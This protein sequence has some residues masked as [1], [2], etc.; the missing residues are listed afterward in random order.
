MERVG[1]IIDR[2]SKRLVDDENLYE[3]TTWTRAVILNGLNYALQLIATVDPTLFGKRVFIPIPDTGFFSSP[4]GEIRPPFYLVDSNNSIVKE[5][6]DELP[7]STAR[8]IKI[9]TDPEQTSYVVKLSSNEFEIYPKPSKIT[10]KYRISALCVDVESVTSEEAHVHLPNRWV[11]ALEELI[12][13][14]CL[15]M[16]SESATSSARADSHY[17][18]AM[19]L[20][21]LGLQTTLNLGI[22]RGTKNAT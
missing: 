22:I 7:S 19:N 2:I 1:N 20:L 3:N 13:Y 16:D 18:V 11:P 8:K 12:L 15:K 5:L 21:G 10:G 6:F 14:Y 17:E 9:C 4:C